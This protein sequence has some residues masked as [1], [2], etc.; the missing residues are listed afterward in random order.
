[1][2]YITRI[3]FGPLFYKM[4]VREVLLFN[5]PDGKGKIIIFFFFTDN[6][7]GGKKGRQLQFKIKKYRQAFI[8]ETM[9]GQYYY[10]P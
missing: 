2:N 1:M 3:V 8:H 10:Y 7:F 6:P 4:H 9:G 5:V